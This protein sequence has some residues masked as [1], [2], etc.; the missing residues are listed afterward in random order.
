MRYFTA[1]ESHGRGISVIAYG[2][3]SNIPVDVE[4]INNELSRRQKGYGRGD[5]MRIERDSVD[6]IG[7]VRNGKTI[8]GPISMVIWNKDWDNWKDKKVA[9]VTKPRPGH[10]DLTGVLKYGF[11]DIRDVLERASARE[12]TARV[13]VGAIAKYVLEMF[14]DVKIF[15]HVL[16]FGGIKIDLKGLT[17]RQIIENSRIS[18]VSIGNLEFENE[19]KNYID[20]IRSQG[21]TLG[22]VIEVV[23]LNP[24]VGLGSYVH[25]EDKIDARI[26]YAVMSIQAI[27]GVE[28]GMG[29]GLGYMKGSEV[30]DEILWNGSRFLRISN[31]A[32]GIE[33][34]MTNG[35]PIVLRCVMKPIST[36]MKPKRSVDIVTKEEFLA[37]V[38]RSDVTAVPAAGVV[39]ESVVAIEILSALLKRYGGDDINLV[40]KFFESDGIQMNRTGLGII[41][42]VYSE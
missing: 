34:G 39:V 10:A 1:G 38:E 9:K 3:P 27:K 41:D 20:K 12:T 31:N 2:F 21:D 26:S 18:E 24:P 15:S 5:R 13:A 42:K 23:V 32:G 30:H 22:G 35:E 37:H 40:K 4:Y 7:G 33:G 8:G 14:F 11:D 36:L 6:V 25:W 29:F 28:F 17:Y 16:V 19:V